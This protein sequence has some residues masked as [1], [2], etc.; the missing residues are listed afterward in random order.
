MLVSTENITIDQYH[1]F[2]LYFQRQSTQTS[3]RATPSFIL[4]FGQSIVVVCQKSQVAKGL[5]IHPDTLSG[6]SYPG[7][8]LQPPIPWASFFNPLPPFIPPSPP[9]WHISYPLILLPGF[10]F[11]PPPYRHPPSP[12]ASPSPP[13]PPLPSSCIPRLVISEYKK[14]VAE[15]AQRKRLWGKEEKYKLRHSDELHFCA[16][17]ISPLHRRA[18]ATW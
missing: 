3:Y 1:L 7:I 5:P 9:S 16:Y 13:F 18:R 6:M 14:F 2:L 4:Q 11:D 10:L 8:L 17:I 12:P 15:T